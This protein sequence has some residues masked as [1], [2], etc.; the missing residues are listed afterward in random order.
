ML[1]LRAGRHARSRAYVPKVILLQQAVDWKSTPWWRRQQDV[2]AALGKQHEKHAK[3]YGAHSAKWDFA[4]EEAYPGDWRGLTRDKKKWNDIREDWIPSAYKW[5]RL[6]RHDGSQ[7]NNEQDPSKVVGGRLPVL[8]DTP[9]VERPS[10]L[11]IV[12]FED[13]REWVAS[14]FRL[15]IEIIGDG[16][17]V[18][19]WV[20][21]AALCT[22][23]KHRLKVESSLNAVAAAWTKGRLMAKSPAADIYRHDYREYNKR[24]DSLAN[25]AQDTG[26]AH[27]GEVFSSLWNPR[28]ANCYKGH[29]DGSYRE[30]SRTGA[31]GWSNE[32]SENG[33]KWREV[34]W[35]CAPI[36]AQTPM[37]TEVA[38]A[39]Q[40]SSAM[41]LLSWNW[42]MSVD[43]EG[44]VIIPE[45]YH[46]GLVN[47]V[48]VAT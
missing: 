8:M 9:S 32:G 46:E 34:A 10:K 24:A 17:T 21:G 43:E 26:A 2:A 12:W 44:Y 31:I 45:W 5:A 42:P 39:K 33:L 14:D 27:G 20:N 19:D 25:L 6:K 35:G 36:S 37:G 22:H 23:D 18:V 1:L 15:A 29:F 4:L 28:R 40:I 48:L 16:E 41:V 47:R 38:A 7:G 30:P 13:E 11:R 3:T